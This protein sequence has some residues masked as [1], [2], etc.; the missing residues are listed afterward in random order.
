MGA[1]SHY[2]NIPY[3]NRNFPIH[4][5]PTNPE[6]HPSYFAWN[7]AP[8]VPEQ[9]P[10]SNYEQQPQVSQFS[11]QTFHESPLRQ[12]WGSQSGLLDHFAY[13]G[14]HLSVSKE[15]M[16]KKAIT[17]QKDLIPQRR[18][19]PKVIESKGAIQ[20]AGTN[21]KK[22]TQCKN[23]ALME[24]F[25]PRPIYC[26]EHIELDPESIYCK[27][28]S[29]YGKTPGDGKGCKEIVLKEFQRCYKHFG[30]RLSSLPVDTALSSAQKD[31]KRVTEILAQLESE[32]ASAKRKRHDLFQRKNKLIPKFAKMLSQL[33]TFLERLGT[34]TTKKQE[35][36]DACDAHPVNLK[37][38]P[39][40]D[41]LPTPPTGKLPFSSS[42]L[43]DEWKELFV[44]EDA[45]GAS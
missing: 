43:D 44:E 21:L 35:T 28:S 42:L 26:A 4:H 11:P 39:D 45:T 8:Y 6:Q 37:S 10:I 31:V 13:A 17:S 25:G 29:T 24:F 23:A 7:S 5:Q 36:L 2:F 27:C 9:R 41:N 12:S 3:D 20:C 40:V 18:V 22:G 14:D 30:D 32:A 19:R 34:S 16:K 15:I 33:E 38:S 1:R